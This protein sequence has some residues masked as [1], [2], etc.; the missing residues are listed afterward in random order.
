M[1]SVILRKDGSV[2]LVDVEAPKPDPD[3]VLVDVIVNSDDDISGLIEVV[4]ENV[5]GFYKGDPV[6]AFDGDSQWL[7]RRPPLSKAA[8]RNS[9]KRP[10]IIYGAST[11]TG[12][13]GVKLATATNIPPLTAV[14]SQKSSFIQP[15]LE[16]ARATS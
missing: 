6:A 8:E 15:F 5:V 11:A 7:L 9:T 4:D 14:G 12:A 10:L 1:K 3:E 13:F 16:K 2:D